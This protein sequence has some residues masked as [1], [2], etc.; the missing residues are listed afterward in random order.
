MVQ[1]ISGGAEGVKIKEI[2]TIAWRL[3]LARL[4]IS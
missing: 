4:R 3:S 1:I 2:Q